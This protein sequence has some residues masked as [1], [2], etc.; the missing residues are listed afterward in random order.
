MNDDP[1]VAEVRKARM[2]IL[3]SY[4]GDYRAMM[5]D[6]MKKQWTSGHKVTS[7]AGGKLSSEPLRPSDIPPVLHGAG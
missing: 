7:T 6:M 4:G 5:R 3:D 1:I 2:E